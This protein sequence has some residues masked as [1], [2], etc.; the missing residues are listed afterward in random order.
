MDK[1]SKTLQELSK[2]L[3]A[4]LEGDPHC[5]ISGIASLESAK[6]GDLAFLS[7]RQYKRF[8]STTNAS[9]VI[10]SPEDS[11]H[12]LV[13]ALISDNPRLSLAKVAQLFDNQSVSLAGIHSSAIIGAG[14]SIA[15]SASIGPL[16]VI[17]NHVQIE[18]QAVIGAGCMI[19]D[20]VRIGHD[21]YLNPNVTLYH[22]VN[23][24]HSTVI[25]S[26]VVIGSD[27][28]GFANDKGNWI[29]MPHLGSV[30]IGNNVEIG[31]NTT[32]DRGFLENTTIG[33]GVI[34][35]NLVQIA[36]N[37]VIKKRTAIAGCTGIA[38]STTIGENCLI[39][40]SANIAGHI[41]IQ[42]GVHI[43][44][45]SSVTRSITESGVYSSGFPAKPNEVWRKNVARFQSLDSMAKRLKNLENRLEEE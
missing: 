10:I 34:I 15:D 32:I 31:A 37:V 36:H 44:A 23:I 25:H 6:K 7:N 45:T 17:G 27:G 12:C 1:I 18:E 2:L 35:D 39:G 9:A 3:G 14:C 43:T 26:G 11:E 5:V 22:K 21:T 33:D 41:D 38:G 8:L 29:K 30:D 16:C 4:R 28:F 13:H 19:G 24:G 42:D 40:G 20:N